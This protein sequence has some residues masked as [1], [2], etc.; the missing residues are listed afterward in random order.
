MLAR[1]W[2]LPKISFAFDVAHV[3]LVDEGI[4]R[5][6]VLDHVLKAQVI[7]LRCQ[8][9]ATNQGILGEFRAQVSENVN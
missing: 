9:I 1:L 8:G 5:G 7:I 6:L 3:D 2:Q 4:W